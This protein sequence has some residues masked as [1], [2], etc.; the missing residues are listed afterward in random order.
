MGRWEWKATMV[1]FNRIEHMDRGGH[2]SDLSALSSL[3]RT[4]VREISQHLY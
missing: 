3:V 2:A 4:F 1:L